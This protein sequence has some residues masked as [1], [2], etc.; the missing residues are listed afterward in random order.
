MLDQDFLSESELITLMEKNGI[1][2]DASIPTHINNI[3]E[4]GFAK[5]TGT[6]NELVAI[7]FFFFFFFFDKFRSSSCFGALSAW[8]CFDSWHRSNRLVAVS[9]DR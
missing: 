6:K 3:C 9:A 4:R 7:F 8:D 2:T 1:G 5:V